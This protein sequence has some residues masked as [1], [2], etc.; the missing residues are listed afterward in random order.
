[1]Q[2][3]VVLPDWPGMGGGNRAGTVRVAP[4]E[5]RVSGFSISPNLP[6]SNHG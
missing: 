3:A 4:V 2:T 6:D 1:M 5:V